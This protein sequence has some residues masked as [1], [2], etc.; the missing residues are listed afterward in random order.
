MMEDRFVLRIT[1]R[2]VDDLAEYSNSLISYIEKN[3]LFNELNI[4][5][6]E[7]QLSNLI[8]VEHDIDQLDSLQKVKYFEETRNLSKTGERQLVFL[9]DSKTQLFIDEIHMLFDRR[10]KI[11]R[12][13]TVYPDVCSVIEEF[14]PILK[15]STGTIYY[16]TYIV[17]ALVLLTLIMSLFRDNRESIKRWVNN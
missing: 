5:R 14:T 8:R 7:Q 6:K 16:G 12:E 9:Q 2:E 13:L 10:E 11:E 4:F 1:L 17:P 15:S 3:R